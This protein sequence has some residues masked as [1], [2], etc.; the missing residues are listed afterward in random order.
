M[1]LLVDGHELVLY[2]D[3]RNERPKMRITRDDLLRYDGVEAMYDGHSTAEA[4]RFRFGFK[5]ESDDSESDVLIYCRSDHDRMQWMSHCDFIIVNG[6]GP[7]PDPT[8]TA[9]PQMEVARVCGHFKPRS[10]HNV[11]RGNRHRKQLDLQSTEELE[12]N[13][14]LKRLLMV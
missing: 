10:L 8:P 4:V 7:R 5:L 14:L 12:D 11:F 2:R 3:D 1:E 6:R 13:L 9:L